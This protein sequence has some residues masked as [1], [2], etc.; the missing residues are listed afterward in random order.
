MAAPLA[1][2]RPAEGAPGHLRRLRV[3][4][5]DGLRTTVYVASYE[6]ARTSVRVALL[7]RPAPLATWCAARGVDEALVGGFFTRPDTRP[8]GELR[9]RGMTRRVSPF[10]APW[11]G[12]RA[13]LHIE[14][15]RPRIAPRDALPAE[16]RGD[17]LQAGPLLVH[18]GAVTVRDGEDAE[19]FAAGSDQFDSDITTGRY[20]RAALGVADDVLLAVACD[21]RS[22]ADAGLSLAELGALLADLGA[23]EAI[24]LDGGGSTSL[25]CAGELRNRPRAEF[26]VPLPGGRPIATAIVF[27][28]R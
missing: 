7:R 21:G 11:D 18:D 5:H 13:C 24:N 10:D 20:P 23:R 25:V 14:S 22:R 2:P 26:G 8:L 4:L 1:T 19:G 3:V 12:V 9:T 15:G 27:S 28:P 16:P 6:R 17:L